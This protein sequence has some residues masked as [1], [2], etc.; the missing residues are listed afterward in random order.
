MKC[1]VVRCV[2]LTEQ[3]KDVIYVTDYSELIS[4]FSIPI[5]THIYTQLKVKRV[6]LK[7]AR[8]TAPFTATTATMHTAPQLIAHVQHSHIV[9]SSACNLATVL[10]IRKQC[11]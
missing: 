11:L 7:H 5:H 9:G 10:V 2:A 8:I 1:R 4:Y 6:R 3:R